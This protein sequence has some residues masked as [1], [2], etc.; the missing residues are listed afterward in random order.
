[1]RS[2]EAGG[3]ELGDGARRFD[4]ALERL[5]SLAKARQIVVGAA[6]AL[7]EIPQLV[8]LLR[9]L[10]TVCELADPPLEPKPFA[11][12]PESFRIAV[13]QRM[14]HFGEDR[15]RGVG[16]VLL[17]EQPDAIDE[18]GKVAGAHRHA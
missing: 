9:P 17:E 18:R 7:G 14:L 3:S 16:G 8:G 12:E 6:Q 4:A 1:M 13:G 11:L 2:D 5:E 10:D 15:H